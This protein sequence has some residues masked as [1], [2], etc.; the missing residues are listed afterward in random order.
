MSIIMY[1]LDSFKLY[2]TW[3]YLKDFMNI[4]A[5]AEIIAL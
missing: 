2:M 4:L 3:F 1:K 5:D